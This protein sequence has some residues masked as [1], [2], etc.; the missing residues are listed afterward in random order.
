MEAAGV[1][2]YCRNSM[3]IKEGC[4]RRFIAED[5][6]VGSCQRLCL[7]LERPES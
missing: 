7:D 3:Y 4:Y 1:E 6:I 2:P 5:A